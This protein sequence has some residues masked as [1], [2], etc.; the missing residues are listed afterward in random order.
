MATTPGPSPLASTEEGPRYAAL[1]ERAVAF[2]N[3]LGGSV[4]E[5]ALVR[6]V[7]GNAGSVAIWRPLLRSVMAEQ[8]GTVALVQEHW[9]LVAG[10]VET[11][12]GSVLD[13]F[14]A[15]D[16]ET[17]GLNPGNQRVIEIALYRYR[18]GKLAERFES[19][20]NPGRPIPEFITRLTTIRDMDVAEAPPF[21]ELAE[22]VLEFIGDTI[23]VGH[24]VRFDIS[25]VNAELKRAGHLPLIN[26]RLDTLTLGVRY[27]TNL[28]KPSLDRVATAVGLQ[29]RDIHRAGADAA[30]TAEVA[31]RLVDIAARAGVRTVDDL[32][33][34]AMPT[35]QR[36]RDDVG[37]GRAVMDR[38][39]LKDIPKKPGVYIMRN[40]TGEVIY[41]GKAKNLRE[42]LASYYAQ[43][44]GYTR[45][46]DGLLEAMSSVETE[47]VG[48]EL[49]ALIL[50]SQLIQRYQP[51]YNTVLRSSEHYP[52]IRVDITNPWPRITLAKQRKDDGARYYGPYRS[53]SGA[54]RT[55][56]VITN[57]VPLRTCT[58]SFR[59]ARS[60]GNPCLRLDL[61]KCLGPCVGRTM[62]DDYRDRVN[63]VLEFLDG[64]DEGLRA[65][66]WADLEAAAERLDFEKATAL[67]KDLR[68]ALALVEEQ[69]RLR[70]SEQSHNLLLVQLS[71]DPD[72]REV[73]VILHGQIWAQVRIPR[74]PEIEIDGFTDEPGGASLDE[75]QVF[76]VPELRPAADEVTVMDGVRVTELADRLLPIMERAAP[77]P[78]QPLDQYRA[79]EA[80]IVNRWL[81]RNVGHPAILPLDLDRLT[82][83]GY[84]VSLAVK[85]L[86]LTDDALE[87]V[88]QN[89][90][91]PVETADPEPDDEVT[92][93][94]PTSPDDA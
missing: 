94:L 82:D 83:R 65:R 45:K 5:D 92:P 48:T 64:S 93:I 70:V 53:T 62:L 23:L 84:L 25:F 89:D 12:T 90:A 34:M 59:N 57:A 18:E 26:E 30:L 33:T 43:P 66:L 9:T 56:E 49:Q 52:Y 69:D 63:E 4:H 36:P 2:I 7:F 80:N 54:R 39:W 74:M 60:Y 35:Q 78:L 91:D 20:V 81:F 8:A 47:V 87:A 13:E 50:E 71:A 24:N 16:V 75:D 51:R 29:P 11:P 85:V 44:L 14:V 38:S 21:S 32:K 3:E 27:L 73:M 46:M 40:A 19:L 77:V 68:A 42:R 61:G 79:D 15:I 41:V 72:A 55:I 22:R 88:V 37:R 28:R 17:T 10:T 31:L 76:V 1:C 58:R 67:R 86:S 6:H